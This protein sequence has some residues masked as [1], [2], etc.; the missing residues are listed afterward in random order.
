MRPPPQV[1]FVSGEDFVKYLVTLD[2]SANDWIVTVRGRS[3]KEVS[4]E[5]IAN[6]AWLD[7]YTQLRSGEVGWIIDSYLL[8]DRAGAWD[9]LVT[10][11]GDPRPAVFAH[12]S[13]GRLT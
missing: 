12:P 1:E 11:P 7:R 3:G 5:R 6:G 9:V 4:A 13:R 10:R 8:A 2:P